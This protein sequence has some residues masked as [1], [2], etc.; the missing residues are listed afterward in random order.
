MPSR[1]RTRSKPRSAKPPAKQKRS[2]PQSLLVLHFDA[3]KLHED[4]LHLGDAAKLAAIFPE[5]ALGAEVV[6][7][8]VTT[9]ADLLTTMARHVESKRTFDVI[10]AVA[11][12]N[13]QGIRVSSDL[14]MSWDGFAQ[15]L[16]PLR[17][18]RLLLVA[19]QAG[20]A[21]AAET[22]F[23]GLPALRRIFACPVNASKDFGT[24][25]MFAIPYV[26]ANRRPK[27]NAVVLAQ[28]ATVVFTGRQLRE[29]RRT[30]DQG[31]P[32]APVHDLMADLIDPFARRVPQLLKSAFRRR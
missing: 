16:R 4:G 27:D 7:E 2:K 31:N 12:S 1:Q 10:V 15:L 26:V 5:L 25:M 20:R 32:D 17:P 28:V 11:H 14:P 23:N 9:T 19:C 8:D 18:R 29:W 21:D 13:A 30:T 24:A 22:L 6:I 3:D